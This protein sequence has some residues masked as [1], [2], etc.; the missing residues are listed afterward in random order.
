M[1]SVA[2]AKAACAVPL[3]VIERHPEFRVDEYFDA[4]QTTLW[5]SERKNVV[6]RALYAGSS[7]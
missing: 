2:I 1:E 4:I 6:D 3:M 7:L 5:M